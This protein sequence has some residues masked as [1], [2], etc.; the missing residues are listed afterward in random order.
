MSL[1]IQNKKACA[2][3]IFLC[4]I[5]LLPIAKQADAQE[6]EKISESTATAEL[7]ESNG[8]DIDEFS[9]DELL[10]AEITVATKSKVKT[11]GAPS[12][13]SVI[14]AREIEN[15]GARDIED[16]LKSVVGIDAVSDHYGSTQIAVRGI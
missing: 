11:Q 14:T 16:I 6:P 13:V 9:L 10:D 1:Q 8:K 4:L 5:A 3:F 7:T 12:I 2:A 15:M